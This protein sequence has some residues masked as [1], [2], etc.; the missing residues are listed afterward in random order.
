MPTATR[1]FRVFVS[2]TFE[3]LK[4]ERD[5][6][7]RDVFPKLRKLCEENGARFQAIDLRWG[8]RDEAAL[9]QQTMGICLREIERC[10][11]TGIK[12]NF[13]ILLGE[14]YGW[15]PIP[16]RIEAQ[17]LER[18]CSC[19][20]DETDRRLINAWYERDD[21]AI[22]PEYL[23]KARTGEFVNNDHWGKTEQRLHSILR[24]AAREARLT[25]ESLIKYEA[26]ATHQEI[27]KG[28]GETEEDRKHV[29]AFFRDP[30]ANAAEDPDITSLK[31]YLREKLTDRNIRTFPTSDYAKLCVD[32]EELLKQVIQAEAGKYKSRTAL[33][34]EIEAHESF[35]RNRCRHFAGRKNV[36][37]AIGNHIRGGD[38]R[39][40]VVHGRSGCGKSA[41]VAK[42]SAQIKGEM[43]G[44]AL[45][46]RFIG[47]T[48]ESASGI[49]LLHSLCEQL[50]RDYGVTEETPMGFQPLVVAFQERMARATAERPLVLFLDALDQLRSDDEARSF[51]WLRQN[52]PSHVSLVISTTEIPV[53]LQSAAQVAVE[54]FPITEAEELV[55]AWL[56]DAHRGLRSE[57][58]EKVFRSFATSG[59][60]LHLKLAFEEARRWRSFQ[61]AGACTL[62][63]DVSGMIDVLFAR[64]AEEANHGPILVHRSLG[65]LAAARYGLTEDE[66]LDVLADD[67]EVWTDFELRAHH[68]PPARQLPVNVWSRLFLDL[69]PYLN[70]RAAPGGNVMTFYH[71]QVAER[72]AG[73]Y[74]QKDEGP[75]R[76]A[77][78]AG[79]FGKQS[80]WR[81]QVE[82]KANERRITELVQHLIRSDDLGSM[83][84]ILS[85]LD[86]IAA[87]CAAGLV[88]DLELDY[89]DAIAAL[90]EAQAE[91][92]EEARRRSEAARWTE[93]IIDYASQWSSRRDRLARGEAIAEPEPRLPKPVRS[94]EPWSEKR[95]EQEA[96]RIL[97]EPTGWDR[98]RAFQGF[99][100]QESYPL[101]LFGRRLGFVTRQA[102]NKAP[103]GPVHEA[104]AQVI[105]TEEA[106]LLRRHWFGRDEYNPRP[107]LLRTLE[108]HRDAVL[109]VSITPDG[110]RA[111][112]AGLDKTML[113]WDLENGQC[114]RTLEGHSD[115]VM[116]VRVTPDGRRAVSASQDKTLRLWDLEAG[117]CLL[118]LTGHM[119]GISGVD[120]TPDGRR[121]ISASDDKTLRVWDLESG[122]CLRTLEGHSAGVTSVA[123][124]PDGRRAVSGSVCDTLRVWDLENGQCL[125]TLERQMHVV[126]SVSVTPDARRAVSATG[127]NT[128][129]VWDLESGQCLRTLEV[130]SNLVSRACVTADGHWAVSASGD[131]TLRLW[132][133]ESGQCLRTLEGHSKGVSSVSVTA[134]LR[135]AV[136]SSEDKTLKVWD[137]ESRRCLQAAEGH[138]SVVTS[139]SVTQ[140][141]LRAVSGSIDDTLRLWNLESGQCLRTLEGDGGVIVAADG[142]LEGRKSRVMSVSVIPDGRRAVSGSEDK[143]LRVWDLESGKCLRSLQGHTEVVSSVSVTP[144]GRRAVS[145][146]EDT[147]LRVWDLDSGQC[148][149][150]L[151]GHSS[152]VSSVCL[153]H[154]GR[155]AVSGSGD[156]TGWEEPE[157]E[158][159]TLRIWDLDTGQ[160][161]RLLKGHNGVV[162]CLSVTADG[163]RAVSGSADKTLR[164]WNLE[165]AQYLRTLEGHGA[166][167]WSVAVT[168][169]GCHAVSGSL[170][171]TLRMWDL[172]TGA[173]LAVAHLP[174]PIS[175]VSLSPSLRRI[176]VGTFNG[177]VF[178]FDSNGMS[179]NRAEPGAPLLQHLAGVTRPAD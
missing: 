10:Q 75:S 133:L 80:N 24:G 163:R 179:M 69:E 125:R 121:A 29:F 36:L 154:G 32:V 4:G 139:I 107:A 131:K 11:Q 136:S 177:E 48:P 176:V 149:H 37:T 145:G 84:T 166:Y 114:L 89:R 123:V 167:I 173:C 159:N 92:K 174:A 25:P 95:I 77:A 87:K 90:P 143:T 88:M 115:W 113:V 118:I 12:P 127:N 66:M 138:S 60:P 161:L 44:V 105:P 162:G 18:V 130:H 46:Q 54:D 68:A 79:Y 135:R 5:A 49:T 97:A 70:E 21:N 137:L 117:V 38:S 16:A 73:L 126:T 175:A 30:T 147:T 142:P 62:G 31:K 45:I 52:L 81:N 83:Q 153:F 63:N 165:T 14:R 122:E 134:D 71:R 17:E 2:S 72:A 41:I 76:H 98:L 40:L 20:A 13:I 96:E 104:A 74:L 28:L 8:V 156:K 93:E 86:F 23:L 91:L 109:S 39:P 64:L 169:D 55:A 1:T 103:R 78:L 57:Q 170:D 65:F 112:S 178:Q 157:K 160:C 140:D 33:D 150:T 6:L 59:L 119:R 3:D 101:Q 99:V 19:V 120:V 58:R 94:A 108:G 128:L 7:Q 111:V 61:E 85:D 152:A 171:R 155:R 158:D 141:G 67:N 110:R 151:R 43:P 129:Q 34:L 47:V 56:Q 53:G 124:T 102:L 148:L 42:A 164:V 22:P 146:S 172:K 27:L 168:P 132:D 15:R 26:S 35:A 9:D 144:D 82:M 106:P 116:S 100:Q 50:S 51:A